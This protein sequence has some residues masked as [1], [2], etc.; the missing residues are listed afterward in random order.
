MCA[1]VR[2]YVRVRV[3]VRARVRARVRVLQAQRERELFT[4]CSDL[5]P[6]MW[7]VSTE[8]RVSKVY[9]TVWQPTH[10]KFGAG[11]CTEIQQKGPVINC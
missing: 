10:V 1:C 6:W 7:L 9:Y 4:F 5:L 8:T 2:A 3:C 11:R